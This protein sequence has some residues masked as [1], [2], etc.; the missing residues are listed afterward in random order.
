[1]IEIWHIP[2]SKGKKRAESTASGE[3]RGLFYARPRPAIGRIAAAVGF[4]FSI[5]SHKKGG[6]KSP[7][8]PKLKGKTVRFPNRDIG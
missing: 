2:H 8:P 5:S 7:E 1:M 3:I 6:R 4:S